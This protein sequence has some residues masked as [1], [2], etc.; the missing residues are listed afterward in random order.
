MTPVKRSFNPEVENR[1]NRVSGRWGPVEGLWVTGGCSPKAS[2]DH[3]LP[4]SLPGY[5]TAGFA[6]PHVPFVVRPSR[7]WTTSERVSWS[8]HLLL[9][10]L[11]SQ[12][13][14]MTEANPDPLMQMFGKAYP[15]STL[16]E[17]RPLSTSIAFSNLHLP[18]PSVHFGVEVFYRNDQPNATEYLRKRPKQSWECFNG[19]FEGKNNME[20]RHVEKL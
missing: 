7:P 14:T 1:C 3:G 13:I 2:W 8:S 16:P 12:A 9:S 18:T 6:L 10:S 20:S 4:A 5:E 11:P 15:Q 17:R 19:D